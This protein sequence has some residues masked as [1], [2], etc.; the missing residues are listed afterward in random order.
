M[1]ETIRFIISI[2][3]MLLGFIAELIFSAIKIGW[4]FRK[5]WREEH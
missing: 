4:I 5:E 3:F 1:L 2:P